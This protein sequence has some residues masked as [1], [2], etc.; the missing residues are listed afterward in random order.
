MDLNLPVSDLQQLWTHLDT[1]CEG[2]I[3]L[4]QF[5]Y[6]CTMLM[7][8]AKRF[9]MA[10][11]SARLNGKAQFA[12]NLTQRCDDVTAAMD[13]VFSKLSVGFA[14]CRQHVLSPEIKEIFPEVGL[15]RAGRMAMP[16][17]QVEE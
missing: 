17:P 13:D 12:E 5:E 3:T 11:L 8:P 6:G 14:K 1:Y 7:E 16:P 15:R 10:C 9:D 4:D 2:E